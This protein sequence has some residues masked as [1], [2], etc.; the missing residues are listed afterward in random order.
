MS[1]FHDAN[2]PR[3]LSRP[4]KVH[5][6]GWESDTLRL[7]QAGWQLS[8][9]Q[10]V[11]EMRMALGLQYETRNGGVARGYGYLDR[12]NYER[13]A[14]QS[15]GREDYFDEVA[16]GMALGGDIVIHGR[17]PLELSPID[18]LPQLSE[19]P[20]RRLSDL[21]CFAPSLAR[22]QQ[23]IVP[24]ETVPELLDKIL[25]MQGPARAARLAEEVRDERFKQAQQR[26][27]FHAQIIS[28]AA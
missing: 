10:D 23:I 25:K 7:Q 5:W 22:T 8:M 6:A 18:A 21:A 14:Y 27:K 13:A 3:I 20:I 16:I 19:M 28:L 4:M 12:F 11:A 1:R 17:V 15:L 2:G 24:E 26:Q 9:Q